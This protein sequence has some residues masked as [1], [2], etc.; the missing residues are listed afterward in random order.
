MQNNAK[1][2]FNLVDEL[3][4]YRKME[5]GKSQLVIAEVNLVAFVQ[6]IF[7]GF[8]TIA[9]K[10]NIATTF[11]SAEEPLNV[12][13]DAAQIEKVV[14]N[15]L[16]NAFKFTGEG[17]K[18][19]LKINKDDEYAYITVS[20]TG[21]GIPTA[22]QQ[23]IFNRF[24]QHDA[25]GSGLEKGFGMGL[26]IV[27]DIIQLHQG[28]VWVESEIN[29]GSSFVVKLVLGTY[30]L[31]SMEIPVTAIIPEKEATIKSKAASKTLLEDDRPVADNTLLIVEDNEEIRAYLREILSNK[32]TILEAANG[33][34]GVKIACNHIPD[35]IIS[36]VLMPIKNGIEL[37]KEVKADQ[38]SSHIPIIL[39]TSRVG[40]VFKKEGYDIG[41][42]AYIT[43]PFNEEILKSRIRNLIK[44]RQEVWK[45][46]SI[47]AITKP[48]ELAISNPDR[49]F[50]EQFIIII[51]E[52]I[53]E[54]VLSPDLF[55]KK[56]GYEPFGYLQKTKTINGDIYSGVYTR[57]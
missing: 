25:Q 48:Q 49:L 26:S 10:K 5:T 13:I 55:A 19:E 28:K 22:Q 56:N 45:S 16:S 4:A 6:E 31:S 2:L 3:L 50:L 7:L 27:K 42:D 57:F 18:I 52:N 51:E 24:Y 11:K 40:W 23:Q 33:E 14:Y 21:I 36:D 46:I 43:K 47:A 8:E 30:H 34:E 41:A 9:A 37:V 35:L 44:S 17:G 54:T 39:L 29:K 12:W 15:L 32:Y 1:H 20:D 53:Q 38:R